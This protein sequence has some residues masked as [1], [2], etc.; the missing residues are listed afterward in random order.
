MI[1]VF[2]G[3]KGTTVEFKPIQ[4]PQFEKNGKTYEIVSIRRRLGGENGTWEEMDLSKLTADDINNFM[5]SVQKA[6][7]FIDKLG[8]PRSPHSFTLHFKENQHTEE[9]FLL[10]KVTYIEHQGESAK[11][12][13]IDL[14]R[15]SPDDQARMQK[16]FHPLNMT[17]KQVFHRTMDEKP[18]ISIPKKDRSATPTSTSVALVE[19]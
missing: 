2:S 5:V 15:L 3:P 14:T 9:P 6:A 17:I 1:P 8:S 19:D 11:T 12:H 18:P 7:K 10:D 4:N 16:K 13:N